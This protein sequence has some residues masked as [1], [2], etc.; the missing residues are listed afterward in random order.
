MFLFFFKPDELDMNHDEQPQTKIK[1]T[2]VLLLN[3]HR[4]SRLTLK[5]L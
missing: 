1:W 5:T 4:I 2:G 3:V